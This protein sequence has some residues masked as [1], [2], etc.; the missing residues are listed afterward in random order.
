MHVYIY[1][2]ICMY[3]YIN[4]DDLERDGV[5]GD[6][7]YV[8]SE[9]I[10][11][12]EAVFLQSYIPSSLSDI[13]NPMQEM[14]RLQSAYEANIRKMLAGGLVGEEENTDADIEAA[15]EVISRNGLDIKERAAL[16]REKNRA[17]AASSGSKKILLG[18]SG[19]GYSHAVRS[20]VCSACDFIIFYRV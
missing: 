12:E 11:M 17:S 9:E 15:V 14:I 6:E 5:V 2:Y 1:I 16:A 13:G 10:R 8:K 20:L 4:Q 18:D 19:Y 7:A 3:V